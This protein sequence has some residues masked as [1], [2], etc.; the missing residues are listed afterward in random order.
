MDESPA[1]LVMDMEKLSVE[2]P[3][4]NDSQP[5]L[6]ELAAKV[7]TPV[8]KEFLRPPP[9]RPSSSSTGLQNDTVSQTKVISGEEKKSKR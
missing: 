4:S 5:T 7:I 6:E 9:S 1:E 8:K 2:S 3:P